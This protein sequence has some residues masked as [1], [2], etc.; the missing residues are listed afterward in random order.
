MIYSRN[1]KFYDL[2]LANGDYLQNCKFEGDDVFYHHHFSGDKIYNC[3]DQEHW[4][5][6]RNNKS[7]KLLHIN[8]DETFGLGF[9][10]ALSQT[11][12]THNIDPTQIY[13]II[14]S[15]LHKDFLSEEL[16][17]LNI[18]GINIGILNNALVKVYISKNIDIIKPVKKF[19]ALSR[20]F[21]QWRLN[22]YLRLL[23]SNLLDEFVYSFHNID[24]YKNINFDVTNYLKDTNVEIDTTVMNWISKIPYRLDNENDD[25]YDVWTNPSFDTILSSDFNLVVETHYE[26]KIS[27]SSIT[28]KTFKAIVC[29]KPFLMFSV[30]NFLADL[31]ETGFKTFSPFINESYDTI[32]DNEQRLI[33]LVNEIKRINDLPTDEYRILLDHCNSI[34]AENFKILQDKQEKSTNEDNFNSAFDFL[35]PYLQRYEEW[36]YP[37]VIL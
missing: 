15:S 13:V 30:V 32:N 34:A 31:R 19:S 9:P 17:K 36:N 12:K 1:N 20:Y 37:I 28:E 33:A 10:L 14:P 11:I 27:V 24:P 18:N 25:S 3:I 35:K 2:R 21:K 5:H 29:N 26:R 4:D 6:I 22:L 8:T 7:V 16:S 23:K